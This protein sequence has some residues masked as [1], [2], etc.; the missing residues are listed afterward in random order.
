[1][2]KGGPSKLIQE[3]WVFD[4]GELEGISNN[5]RFLKETNQGFEKER[6]FFPLSQR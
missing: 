2:E 5:R 4:E 1:M 6:T 3:C